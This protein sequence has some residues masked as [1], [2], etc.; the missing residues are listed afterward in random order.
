MKAAATL[1]GTLFGHPVVSDV[2]LRWIDHG[3]ATQSTLRIAVADTTEHYRLAESSEP[4]ADIRRLEDGRLVAEASGFGAYVLDAASMTV[5]A[6]RVGARTAVWEHTLLNW[7][8]PFLLA[9][10]ATLVLHGAAIDTGVGTML[11]IGPST[12]GKTT[13]AATAARI[14]YRVLGE[15]GIAIRCDDGGATAFPGPPG[16]R[17]RHRADGTPGRKRASALPKG[18]RCQEPTRLLG[19]LALLDR[20]ELGSDVMTLSKPQAIAALR[21]N[22][23]AATDAMPN[24]YPLMA[25]VAGFAPVAKVSLRNGLEHLESEV[26]R[27]VS[28]TIGASFAYKAEQHLSVSG[29]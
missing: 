11:V 25:S 13:F 24:L 12:R 20:T 8:I 1:R 19:V 29:R 4:T 5:T 7:A 14:G 27:L 17:L 22:T 16:V 28:W 26:H 6:P 23:L 3:T 15:D 18:T 21:A 2:A 10:T 9:D